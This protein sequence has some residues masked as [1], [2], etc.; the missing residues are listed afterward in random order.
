MTTP[1]N[2]VPTEAERAAFT[3]RLQ[4]EGYDEI[5][6]KT[7]EP[8]VSIDRHVHPYDVLALVLDGEATIDC[9]QGARTYR[10]GDVLEVARDVPHTERYGPRGYTFLLGR[11]HGAA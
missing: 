2:A 3:A 8:D 4:R 10:P 11:R 7:I 5:L 9:G 1:T 6:T